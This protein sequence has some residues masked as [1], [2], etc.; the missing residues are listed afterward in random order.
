MTTP[1]R[2]RAPE[3]VV[4]RSFNSGSGPG[5]STPK[6]P[7]FPEHPDAAGLSVPEKIKFYA[8][9]YEAHQ[10]RSSTDWACPIDGVPRCEARNT[11]I[12]WLNRLPG[13]RD[14]DEAPEDDSSC[15]A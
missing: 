11:A 1:G 10:G 3:D 12:Y 2:G 9:L 8:E 14:G 13:K 7:L 5:S 4:R 15:A 6:G